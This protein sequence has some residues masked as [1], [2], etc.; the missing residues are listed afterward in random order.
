[1]HENTSSQPVSDIAESNSRISNIPQLFT[2]EEVAASFRVSVRSV[3][4]YV[5]NGFL[6]CIYLSPRK[7][8]IALED[9][10]KFIDRVRE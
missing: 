3:E 10:E 7:R 5:K 4:R 6:R 8:R 2:F 9:L 1:M